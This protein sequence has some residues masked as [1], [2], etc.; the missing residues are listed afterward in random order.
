MDQWLAL[1]AFS[2]VSSGSPGPNNV[3]LWASGAAFGFRPTMPHILGTALGIGALA[4]IAAAGLAAIVNAV[5][6]LALVMKLVASLYLLYLAWQVAGVHAIERGELGH[7]MSVAQAAAFQAINP[8]G[9]VFALGAIAAFRPAD[10]PVVPGSLLVAGTMTA[11][12]L[13][14]AALWAAA[15]GWLGS[16]LNGE[17]SRRGVSLLLAA[18]LVTSVAAIWR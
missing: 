12:V 14:T 8:K 2:I 9:W 7:P 3:L 17:R 1:V 15:G 10:L 11:I 18:L 6:M 5:P 4:L 13:P 16:L